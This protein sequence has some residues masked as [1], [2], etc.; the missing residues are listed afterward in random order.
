MRTIGFILLVGAIPLAAFGIW[1]YY[2]D[3]GRHKYDEMAAILPF[4]SMWGAGILAV[5]G[6]VLLLFRRSA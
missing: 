2:T 6:V 3:A 4:F 5:I 1:G